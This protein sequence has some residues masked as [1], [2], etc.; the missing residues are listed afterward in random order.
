MRKRKRVDTSNARTGDTLKG[1]LLKTE[2]CFGLSFGKQTQLPNFLLHRS[3]VLCTFFPIT[4]LISCLFI[5][6][7]FPFTVAVHVLRSVSSLAPFLLTRVH[8]TVLR[9]TNSLMPTKPVPWKPNNW[10]HS[11]KK[12]RTTMVT[13]P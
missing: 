8:P 7:L 13:V 6:V 10:V 12:W 5:F 1:E 11:C 3:T 4:F 9:P 2:R